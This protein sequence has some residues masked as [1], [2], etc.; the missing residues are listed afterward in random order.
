[1]NQV[2]E[3]QKWKHSAMTHDQMKS[4]KVLVLVGVCGQ[5]QGGMTVMSS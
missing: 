2:K 5:I 3:A 1:M 4:K